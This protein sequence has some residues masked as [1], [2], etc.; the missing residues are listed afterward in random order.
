[1]LLIRDKHST[2]GLYPYTKTWNITVLNVFSDVLNIP[3]Q[4][5]RK[6]GLKL[7]YGNGFTK[8]VDDGM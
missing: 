6:S 3:V 8:N 4:N 7:G 5:P 2:T 1:M